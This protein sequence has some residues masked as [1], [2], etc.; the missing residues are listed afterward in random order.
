[1]TDLPPGQ[2]DAPPACCAPQ[3][4]NSR[5]GAYYHHYDC[6]NL[7]GLEPEP[8]VHY[9]IGFRNSGYASCRWCGNIRPRRDNA[10]PCRGRVRVTLR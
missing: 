6:P 1:M 7:A 3:A 10:P 4:D 2:L 5:P 8:G 9:W